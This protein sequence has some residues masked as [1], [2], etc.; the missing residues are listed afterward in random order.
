MTNEY[1]WDEDLKAFVLPSRSYDPRDPEDLNP[2]ADDL[3]E[4]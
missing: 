1:V 4:D 2:T 3:K